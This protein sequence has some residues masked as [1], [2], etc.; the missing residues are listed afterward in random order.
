MASNEQFEE[1]SIE[2]SSVPVEGWKPYRLPELASNGLP[3]SPT[4]IL[5]NGGGS[6]DSQIPPHGDFAAIW[7]SLPATAC[8]QQPARYRLDQGVL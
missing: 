2:I 3:F 1:L 4:F 8:D 6:I 5:P 7:F